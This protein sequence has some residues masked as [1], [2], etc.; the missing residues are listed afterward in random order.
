MA[1]VS[2]THTVDELAEM[3][4][5]HYPDAVMVSLSVT[6]DGH[7]IEVEHRKQ[8]GRMGAPAY[9]CLDGQ[10]VHERKQEE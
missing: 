4:R 7:S 6:V 10:W 5:L 2:H 9:R 8:S 3:L 1:N